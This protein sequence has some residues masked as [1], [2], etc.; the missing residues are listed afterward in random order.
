MI[1]EDLYNLD[2]ISK[3]STFSRKFLLQYKKEAREYLFGIKH[4]EKID[5][6]IEN[7][8]QVVESESKNCESCRLLLINLYKPMERVKNI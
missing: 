2:E 3:S 4:S 8:L 7:S 5:K 1:H 6:L